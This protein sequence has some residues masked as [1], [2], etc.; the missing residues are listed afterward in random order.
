MEAT[1][2]IDEIGGKGK[3]PSTK[4]KN[5]EFQADTETESSRANEI[6]APTSRK[7]QRVLPSSVLKDMNAAL[8]STDD[9][10][11]TSHSRSKAS[12]LKSLKES[13]FKPPEVIIPKIKL[14][15]SQ[16][17]VL[18]VILKRKSVFFTGAAGNNKYITFCVDIVMLLLLLLSL[19]IVRF[20]IL[21]CI[22]LI[23]Q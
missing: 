18:V 8:A 16:M 12:L 2:L 9:S 20:L 11:I 5:I 23:K 6:P 14:S 1:T 13:K 15:E 3:L 19:R 21:S 4:I 7:K 10:N 22:L 17:R